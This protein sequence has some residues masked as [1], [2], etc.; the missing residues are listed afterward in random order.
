MPYQDLEVG[1]TTATRSPSF[2]ETFFSGVGSIGD[3]LTGGIYD[4]KGQN[5]FA[6]DGKTPSTATPSWVKPIGE[7]PK[8]S[9]VDAV[10]TKLPFYGVLW[11]R[12][13]GQTILTNNG[14]LAALAGAFLVYRM[15]R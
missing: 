13:D 6:H 12:R 15:V 10:A 3:N 1:G 11:E 2:F 4:E 14:K 7:L 9:V 8:F 5:V